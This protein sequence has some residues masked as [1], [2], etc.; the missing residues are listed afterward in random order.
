MRRS[1]ASMLAVL[2]CL[3]TPLAAQEVVAPPP[4]PSNTSWGMGLAATLGGGWQIEGGDLAL[5]RRVAA[6]PVQYVGA[7]ARIGSFIDEGAIIGGARGIVAALALSLRTGAATIAEI[8]NE[9]DVTR[10][11]LDLT[12][13]TGAW[14]GSNSPLPQ[15]SRWLTVAAL[16]GISFGSPG[17]IQYHLVVG[18]VAFLGRPTDVRTFLGVRFEMPLARRERRP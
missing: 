16:P 11:G 6:G 18:P 13:E 15:G 5:T 12:V 4:P 2:G 7:A 10:I 9:D 17:G 3:S 1:I 8:G 14:V